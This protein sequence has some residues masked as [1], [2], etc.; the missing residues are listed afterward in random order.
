[1][2]I[3]STDPELNIGQPS[4]TEKHDSGGVGFLGRLV[5]GPGVSLIV[6][7]VVSLA[8]W[9]GAQANNVD[10]FVLQAPL[11]ENWWQLP[12][13]VFSHSGMPHLTGNATGVAI[14]GSIVVLSSSLVRYHLF[15]ILTG[16]I[17]GVGQVWATGALGRAGAVL[18]ASGAVMALFAYVITSNFVS[19]AVL[20]RA[21]WWVV[22]AFVAL[23]A[24]GL[25]LWSAGA[26]VANMG[27]LT[28]AVLGA[29]AGYF[30]FLRAD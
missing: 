17:A 28:G 25:T 10:P 13:S 22:G 27:H 5:A 16:I 7:A 20:K 18:G 29:V 23:T 21:P 11:A 2:L 15:F 14:F 12:L 8:T 3:M 9:T 30:H 6:M 24:L 1:M 19:G 26:Q 4:T